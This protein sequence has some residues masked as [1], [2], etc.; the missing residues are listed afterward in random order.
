MSS[1]ILRAREYWSNFWIMSRVVSTWVGSTDIVLPS[2][3][4]AMLDSRI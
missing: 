3:K 1:W 4:Q 2:S